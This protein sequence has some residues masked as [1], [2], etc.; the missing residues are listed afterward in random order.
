[1]QIPWLASNGSR[2]HHLHAM[3]CLVAFL[4]LSI[5]LPSLAQSQEQFDRADEL[6]RYAVT[7]AVCE[8]L[9][10]QLAPNALDKMGPVFLADVKSW[11]LSEDAANKLLSGATDRQS[12]IMQIDL[13]ALSEKTKTETQLRAVRSSFFMRYGPTCVRAAADPLF[14]QFLTAPKGFNLDAAATEAADSL[15]EGGGLANWQ[16]AGI[17]ARGDLM[18]AAGTCRRHIG[19]SRSD[20]IFQT[21]SHVK[22]ARQRDYYISQYD[23]GLK[24]TEL[25]LDATQ[26]ERLITRLKKKVASL[27][28]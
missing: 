27:A 21:Y 3:R 2:L 24:D 7:V 8:K 4:A 19:P 14:K 12:R 28:P 1:M 6:A 11:G 5:T 17:Q 13:G 9:G 22:D 20:A 15:L 23:E 10:M 18:M 25:N 26:C 16:T